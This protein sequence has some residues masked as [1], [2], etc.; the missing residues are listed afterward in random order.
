MRGL[1]QDWPLL[2]HKVIDHAATQHGD[3]EVIS[4]SVEGPIHRTNYREVR[5]RARRVAKRLDADGFRLG[6]RAATLA[7]NTWRHLEVWYGLLG[8][9]SVYHTVNPRLFPDQIAWI[10]NDAEDRMLFVDLTFLPIVEKL[11]DQLKSI[12]EDRRADRRRAHART[13]RSTPSPTRNGSPRTR[14][15]PGASSTKT[16]PPACATPPARPAIRRASSTRTARTCC[17]RSS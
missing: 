2:C 3:R 13:R 17:T 15:S 10:I 16:P 9:G 5:A 8:I 7:W 1:M 11:R 12:E 6:D 14:T 4:R